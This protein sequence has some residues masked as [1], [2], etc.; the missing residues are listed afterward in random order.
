MKLVK[1]EPS[2]TEGYKYDAVF[3]DDEDKEKPKEKTVHF[4]AS[5]YKDHIIYSKEDG[6]ILA[7]QR[8]DLYI[9]R[10]KLK[11]DWNDPTSRGALSRWILW[12]LPT[13]EASIA[14]YKRRFSLS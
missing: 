11:E 4:G 14:D 12:N 3:L 6:K 13:L 2:K 7:N 9:Q 1:I 5:G 10:H 8:K